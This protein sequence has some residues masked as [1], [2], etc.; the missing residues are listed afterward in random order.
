MDPPSRSQKKEST[1]ESPD[2][3]E[4]V[5]T[6]EK[7]GLDCTERAAIRDCDETFGGAA[8]CYMKGKEISQ[9][10]GT[11]TKGAWPMPV[12]PSGGLVVVIPG[13]SGTGGVHVGW[14]EY[15]KKIAYRKIE[16]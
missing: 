2:V 16:N 15:Q 9:L 13:S 5:M 8:G 4:Y 6:A 1:K 10:N 3:A 12:N 7:K 14:K 11:E